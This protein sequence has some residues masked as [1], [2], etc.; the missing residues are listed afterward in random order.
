MTSGDWGF[1]IEA[2]IGLASLHC[3]DGV[4]QDWIDAGGF[5]VQI[6]GEMYPLKVQ[7]A[8]FYDPRGEIMRG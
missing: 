4:S 7:L 8:P 3:G 6:A 5:E 1:R 2:M